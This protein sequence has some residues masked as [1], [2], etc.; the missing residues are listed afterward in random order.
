ML[1]PPPT[2][3][4]PVGLS[5]FSHVV[6]AKT[7]GK[8]KLPNGQHALVMEEI[9]YNVHYP[10][11]VSQRRPAQFVPWLAGP[12]ADMVAGF[13]K[14]T[15]LA[16][17]GAWLFWPIIYLYLQFLKL[18]LYPDAPLLDPVEGSAVRGE[19]AKDK[20][21]KWPLVI[22][23]HGLG[24]SRTTYS[25]FCSE[26]ASEGYIVLAIEHRDASGPSVRIRSNGAFRTLNYLPYGEIVCVRRRFVCPLRS[27]FPPLTVMEFRWGDDK[28][29][30]PMPFRS[31]GLDFRTVEVYETYRTFAELI[32][33]TS[34]NL[35]CETGG[36]TYPFSQWIDKVDVERLFLTGHSFGGATALAVLRTP[37]P[38]SYP[39]L[40]ISHVLL[41]DPWV[42]P[43]R[44][45]TVTPSPQ[46]QLAIVNSENFTLWDDHFHRLKDIAFDCGGTSA[47]L[48]TIVRAGHQDF[49]DLPF[50][51]PLRAKRGLA[52][53]KVIRTLSLAFLRDGLQEE[54]NKEPRRDKEVVG[55][56]RKERLVGNFAEV[57]LHGVSETS[58]DDLSN[59]TAADNPGDN[60]TP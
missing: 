33:G 44:R 5:T 38:S 31:E 51:V 47:K 39:A 29:D 57:L 36:S 22:F 25:Y 34:E 20:S 46:P 18:P 56:N 59:I 2:G 11:H 16:G 49:S 10:C 28:P 30:D 52:L 58:S 27:R 48:M 1:L 24:G 35:I 55:E 60:S 37:P 17:M 23:S 7:Y 3:P 13:V 26:L 4:Y 41:L 21:A 6:P 15:E 54:L 45:D 40:P 32:R 53:A 12:L 9:L 43:L 19:P 14:F 8:S 50:L 42:D